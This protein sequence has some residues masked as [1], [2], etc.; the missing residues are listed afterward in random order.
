MRP[1]LSR[2]TAA[3]VAAMAV[4]FAGIVSDAHAQAWKPTR[5]VEFVVPL[6]PGGGIDVATRQMHQIMQKNGLIATSMTVVNKPGAAS[7][8]GYFYVSQHKA[9]PHFITTGMSP[10]YTNALTGK[11]PLTYRDLTLICNLYAEYTAVYVREDSD[12]KSAKDLAEKL[13]KDPSSVS[14]GLTALG[15]GHY[16]TLVKFMIAN[17]LDPKTL[18]TVVFNSTGEAATA[19][20]GGHINAVAG[21]AAGSVA[22]LKTGGIRI[23]GV[24]SP[25]P[26][27]EGALK[28]SPTWREQGFDVVNSNWRGI[29]GPPGLTPAQVKYWE[30]IFAKLVQTDE[31]KELLSRNSWTNSFA[32]ADEF[33]KFVQENDATDTDLFKRLGMVSK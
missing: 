24:S 28:G 15:A 3:T 1:N 17:G 11:H 16:F 21:S 12:I 19:V 10:L 29:V 33:K 32:R 5:N 14:F 26:I 31:W 23:I 18:K 22:Q 13:K 20:R 6:A 27:T 8:I 9:N 30:D 7:A 25:E 4:A 2:V